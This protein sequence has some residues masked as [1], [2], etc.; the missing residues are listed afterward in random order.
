MGVP[1]MG[2][3]DVLRRDTESALA[4][5]LDLAVYKNDVGKGVADSELDRSWSSS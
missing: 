5:T 1:D 3:L 2:V 4:V